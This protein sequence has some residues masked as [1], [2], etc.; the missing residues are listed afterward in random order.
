V[1]PEGEYLIIT[2]TDAVAYADSRDFGYVKRDA[3]QKKVVF[4]LAPMLGQRELK[5]PD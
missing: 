3:I 2:D 1:I 4:N 5:Q